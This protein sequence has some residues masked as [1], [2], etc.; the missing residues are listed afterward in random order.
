VAPWVDPV[1]GVKS[2]QPSC[3]PDPALGLPNGGAFGPTLV[4]FVPTIMDRLD[5]AGLTWKIYAEHKNGYYAVC[6]TFAECEYSPQQNQVVASSSVISDAQ[7]GQLPSFA[8][9][10]PT[11]ANSQH[12]SRS[13]AAGDNWIGSVV[14]AIEQ[15]PAWGSTAI[16]ITYDDCGCFYDHVRPSKNPD[17]TQ[18][19][20]RVPMVIVSPWARAAYTDSTPASFASILAFT[21]HTFGLA[22]L[23]ANDA[24][25]YDFRNTFNFA[26]LPN[27]RPVRMVQST[28]PAGEQLAGVDDLNDPT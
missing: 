2:L 11:T 6:P 12:N 5:A 20:P 10:T 24:S 22:S 23:S 27:T 17:G 1:T 19:G 14:S 25:A 8:L 26:L 9:V 18:Q 13:M 3:V 7:S 28:I 16:F 15:G 4:Q 21:E